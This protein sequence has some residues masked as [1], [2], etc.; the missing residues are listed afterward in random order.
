VAR[1]FISC[2][3]VM[4]FAGVR[5]DVRYLEVYPG[6]RGWD[7]KEVAATYPDADRISAASVKRIK[8]LVHKEL[9]DFTFGYNYA[10]P[11]EVKDMPETFKERCA[12]GAW[13]LD[14]LP[15]TYQ[16]KSSPYHVW[17]TYV[18][19]M[20]SWGD[21]V[22][23]LGGVY[24][25]YD[26]NRG[27]LEHPI[28]LIYSAIFRVICG[29]RDYGGWYYNSRQ[30]VGDLGAFTTRFSEYLHNVNRNWI[31]ELK[32][33][34]DVASAAPLWWQDMCYWTRA[35]DGRKCLQ[36]N[37]VNPPKVAEV[38]E[39]PRSEV[40]PPVRDVTVT[41]AL[42]DGQKPTAAYLLMSEPLELTD[43]NEVQVVKLDLRDAGAGRVAVTV[44]SVLFWK[45]VVFTW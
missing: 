36:V 30:P 4:G 12:G 32:G 15:C 29:G 5:L 11:E 9:P 41:C 2:G 20:M 40:N 34:V 43:L 19:R 26:F 35:S 42:L 24:N 31:A 8:A 14:E 3:K 1:Q 25:P 6:E 28:D 21:Q 37:L 22:T 45:M 18:R 39:N 27:S 23:K 17:K 38:L 10:A 16:E 33:E 44:P 13:M 7:G